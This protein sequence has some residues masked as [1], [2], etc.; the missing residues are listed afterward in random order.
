[1]IKNKYKKIGLL[2]LAAI[3]AT[4]AIASSNNEYIVD[5]SGDVSMS[6]MADGFQ[7]SYMNITKGVDIKV[8]G[9][10]ILSSPS[11]YFKFGSAYESYE[12]IF[13]IS[14][15]AISVGCGGFSIKGMF[16][17]ILGIDRIQEMLK[18]SAT[19]FAYG[20]VVGLIYTMPGIF[21]AFQMLNQW[22]K[23]I[24]ELMNNACN[25]GKKV[26]EA[27]GNKLG[28]P[29]ITDSINGFFDKIPSPDG[30][31]GSS[32]AM[33]DSLIKLIG[34]DPADDT[35]NSNNQQIV[36]NTE[37]NPMSDKQ[38]EALLGKILDGT[39]LFNSRSTSIMY[40]S[41]I[42]ANNEPR[43]DSFF[44][45][46]VSDTVSPCS[47]KISSLAGGTNHA[48]SRGSFA[49]T[50]SY[51]AGH[52]FG[53][54]DFISGSKGIGYHSSSTIQ[55][56]KFLILLKTAI[57]KA[58][59]PDYILSDKDNLDKILQSVRTVVE[60][61]ENMMKG[62][63]TAHKGFNSDT[64]KKKVQAEIAKFSTGNANIG[65]PT[66]E[67]VS[68]NPT[69]LGRGLAN[70]LVGDVSSN[71]DPLGTLKTVPPL[72]Y[73]F[74]ALPEDADN[75]DDTVSVSIFAVSGAISTSAKIPGGATNFFQGV[76]MPT[77]SL[78]EVSLD[79]AN[80]I[81]NRTDPSLTTEQIIQNAS[82]GLGSSN[83]PLP[84]IVPNFF[85][86]AR[87]AQESE[88]A[89][90]EKAIKKIAQYNTCQVAMTA[91]SIF[92]RAVERG[93]GKM[94]YGL[95]FDGN[96]V[97]DLSQ[98][99]APISKSFQKIDDASLSSP[100]WKTFNKGFR[101]QLTKILQASP[102][103]SDEADK[104]L[105]SICNIDAMES[106]FRT[107]DSINRHRAASKVDQAGK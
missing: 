84:W 23:K 28:M 48:L 62:V 69:L 74:I 40:A 22:A 41:M 54:A 93:Q 81:I 105:N 36:S 49:I 53:M 83:H 46:N 17:S 11:L 33:A 13:H 104:T 72:G 21:H 12:P 35:S 9:G 4:S 3:T 91:M 65:I 76:T 37:P 52:Q 73:K 50:Y 1:M 19:S 30:I 27:L 5:D 16:M 45:E 38:I 103:A 101:G 97:V 56:T 31:I 92:E 82:N 57:Q 55:L 67:K 14:P 58:V 61:R 8:N 77:K 96:G 2:G 68:G 79:I 94:A 44:C 29:A 64:E 66:I 47:G 99:S 51:T 6:D 42:G 102:F 78:Y 88:P 90:K 32:D 7:N 10:K 100:R 26:G 15:L 89:A 59:V 43:L 63:N 85:E 18:S 24:Q 71:G 60:A 20:I 106:W 95:A 86:F 34:L 98:F 39:R 70:L 25:M 80:G 107:L 87:I 75:A